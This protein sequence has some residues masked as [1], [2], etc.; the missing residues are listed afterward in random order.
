MLLL[1]LFYLLAK[2]LYNSLPCSGPPTHEAE[3]LASV[4]TPL[5]HELHQVTLVAQQ[6]EA[7]SQLCLQD[8]HVSPESAGMIMNLISNLE[9][10]NTGY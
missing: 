10:W 5:F 3:D 1:T 6:R 2:S 7:S 8:L 4:R 9:L